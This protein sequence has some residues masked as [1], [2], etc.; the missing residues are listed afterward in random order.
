MAEV[1]AVS[2]A[3]AGVKPALNIPKET[4]RP[5]E[6]SLVDNQLA[7]MREMSQRKQKIR[8]ASDFAHAGKVLQEAGSV[9]RAFSA[10]VGNV[11]QADNISCCYNMA[12]SH[13]AE[14]RLLASQLD[15]NDLTPD[16]QLI[17][18]YIKDE[19]AP[20]KTSR[21]LMGEVI[22]ADALSDARINSGALS[23]ESIDD[24][25]YIFGHPESDTYVDD[26]VLN[27]ALEVMTRVEQA[28]PQWQSIA[29]NQEQVHAAFTPEDI[30][31]YLEQT[32]FPLRVGR[33][34]ISDQDIFRR[35]REKLLQAQKEGNKAM[36][37][38]TMQAFVIRST[39]LQ[40]YIEEL[41]YNANLSLLKKLEEG[42]GT[43]SP[44]Q[45]TLM[46]GLAKKGKVTQGAA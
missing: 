32:T 3:T 28:I 44:E 18:G 35:Y 15:R 21:E 34:A 22:M 17:F 24:G 5:P 40:A 46:Q 23:P 45:R 20:L 4:Q 8:E 7:G 43:L 1:T 33:K 10:A 2:E 14:E 42:S 26:Q 38:Q 25:E 16:Q 37:K 30:Q 39:L 41:H 27:Q 29:V 36:F 19:A 13:A 11:T 9:A 6:Q 12:G 31:L